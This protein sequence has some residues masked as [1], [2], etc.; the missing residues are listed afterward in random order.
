MKFTKTAKSYENLSTLLNYWAKCITVSGKRS[1]LHY[2]AKIITLSGSKFIALSGDDIALSGDD[3]ALSGNYYIIR[4]FLLYYQAV[5]TLTGDYYITGCNRCLAG[6][7]RHPV[8]KSMPEGWTVL[9]SLSL[10]KESSHISIEIITY[11]I[12]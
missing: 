7:R 6:T 3:I 8:G 4:R 10:K 1:L 11:Y 5:I 12:R 2:Q 9:I